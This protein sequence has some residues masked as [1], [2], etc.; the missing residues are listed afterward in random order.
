VLTEADAADLLAR[1]LGAARLAAE[2]GPVAELIGLCARLPLALA[3]TAARA[4]AHPGFPLAALAAELRDEQGRLSVLDAGDAATSVRAAFS[5]SYRQLT[6]AA[7]RMFRLLGLAPG[8]DIATF[9]AA[10]LAGVPV[11]QASGLLAELTQAH[12]LTEHVAGRYAFHDLLR[13]YAAELAHAHDP[14]D[15]RRAALTGLFD[16]YLATSVAAMDVLVPAEKHRRPHVPAVG[17]LP[18]LATP[19]AARDWLDSERATLAAVSAHTDAHGWPSHTTR[20]AR[21]LFRYLENGGH[22]HDARAIHTHALHAANRTGDRAAEGRAHLAL[23][24][25]DNWQGRCPEAAD[26]D[27]QA[28]ALFREIG[29]KRG[30]AGSLSNLGLVLTRQAR[31][32]QAADCFRQALAVISELGDR[33]AQALVLGNLGAVLCKQGHYQQAAGHHREALAIHREI[34]FREGEAHELCNLGFALYRQ[35]KNQPA[36]D[37]L[38][39]ALDRCHESGYLGEAT[40]LDYLGLVLSRRRRYRQAADHHRQALDLYQRMGN[41]TGEAEALNGLGEA[42][43]AAGQP[44]QARTHHRDALAL[45]CQTGGQYEQARAHDGLARTYH[46]T[47]DPGQARHHWQQALILYIDMGVP[48][49]DQIRDRLDDPGLPGAEKAR[50]G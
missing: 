12:L 10:S 39:Q 19:T 33:F 22:W 44:V 17:P 21:A 25:A 48:E 9:A 20:L 37:Y 36:A 14:G 3:V 26:H 7:A 38:R 32:E 35:G 43:S 2:P 47:G 28:L 18:P 29:D 27:Q 50:S 23:G 24:L 4:A 13:A 46:A 34:G 42:L 8:A 15:E 16:Y 5:W 41:R 31:Y 45:A 30:Q 6:P 1:R 11:P 49:A 40:A